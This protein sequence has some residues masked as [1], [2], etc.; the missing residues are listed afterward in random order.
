M[1]KAYI[2]TP[3][4]LKAPGFFQASFSS[5][6]TSI[7]RLRRARQGRGWALG[8]CVNL[9]SFQMR[10]C[11]GLQRNLRKGSSGPLVQAAGAGIP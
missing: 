3:V 6:D 10:L 9:A 7:G 11:L 2:P 1:Y 8:A 5:L 4:P